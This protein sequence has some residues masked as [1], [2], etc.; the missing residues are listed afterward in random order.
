MD[1]RA[2]LLG[3]K[4]PPPPYNPSA[5]YPP[6][7]EQLPYPPPAEQLPYPPSSDQVRYNRIDAR[8]NISFIAGSDAANN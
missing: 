7:T 4:S 6:P 3:D 1:E 8:I 2:P 5:P